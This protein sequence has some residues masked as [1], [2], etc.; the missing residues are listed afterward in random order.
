MHSP[1]ARLLTAI[2][3]IQPELPLESTLSHLKNK[4]L[5]PVTVQSLPDGKRGWTNIPLPHGGN[6][7]P[8]KAVW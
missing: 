2:H 8:E 1:S 6:R 3:L 4:V 5:I 7:T